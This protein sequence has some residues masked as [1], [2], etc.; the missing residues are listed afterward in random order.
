MYLYLDVNDPAHTIVF[1]FLWA[2]V[3]TYL[4]GDVDESHTY[5]TIYFHNEV[6]VLRV[7]RW[8]LCIF[9]TYMCL[10]IAAV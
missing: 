7:I 5:Q 6:R 9:E 10:E 3:V 1:L 8:T 2:V 4:K